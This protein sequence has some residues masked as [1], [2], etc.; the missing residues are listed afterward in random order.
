[1]DSQLQSISKIFTEKIF[2][3][4]DYQRGYAW[5]NKQLK[6]FWADIL[7]LEEGKNHYVGVLT[8]EGV[9]KKPSIVGKMTNGL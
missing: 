3:I 2:R 4:P 9:Q 8:L 7:L 1:M 5:T 6:D